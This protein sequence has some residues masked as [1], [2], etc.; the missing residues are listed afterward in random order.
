MVA[1]V[2]QINGVMLRQFFAKGLPI[3]E[4]A[5]QP[6]QYDERFALSKGFIVE[7]EHGSFFFCAKVWNYAG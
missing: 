7:F 5:E 6:V 1:L 4:G 3:I 2:Y